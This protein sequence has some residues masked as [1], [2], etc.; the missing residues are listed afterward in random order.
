VDQYREE[1]SM[2]VMSNDVETSR[3]SI[4]NMEEDEENADNNMVGFIEAEVIREV[5]RD[6]PML[7]ESLAKYVLPPVRVPAEYTRQDR[8]GGTLV[9]G[10]RVL[11]TSAAFKRKQRQLMYSTRTISEN[12]PFVNA[13]SWGGESEDEDE[14]EVAV[15]VPDGVFRIESDWI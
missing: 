4:I 10:K 7:E 13:Q 12:L 8:R 1:S 11:F 3:V 15:L 6:A 5:M 2:P 9:A 14:D